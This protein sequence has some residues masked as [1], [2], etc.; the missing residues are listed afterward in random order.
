MQANLVSQ[1]CSGGTEEV[2]KR[3]RDFI[4]KRSGTYDYSTTG[5][6]WT[7]HD[8]YYLSSNENVCAL[9]DWFV[10]KSTGEDGDRDLYYR[11][12]WTSS[13]NLTIEGYLYWN[14]VS[15]VGVSLFSSAENI[16]GILSGTV[17]LWIYGNLNYFLPITKVSGVYYGQY[18]GLLNRV[19][20]NTEVARL[21]SPIVA[22]L[23][24]TLYLDT[25]PTEDWDVGKR[26]YIRDNNH[27]ELIT[28][29]YRDNILK[30]IRTNLTYSY[31]SGAKLCFSLSNYLTGS[32][33]ISNST[34]S[35]R[36]LIGKN[37]TLANGNDRYAFCSSRPT[38]VIN[39]A[40]DPQNSEYAV[41]PVT[42]SS[43][44]GTTLGYCGCYEGVRHIIN[45]NLVN[46][47]VLTDGTDDWRYFSCYGASSS[48]I[49]REV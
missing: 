48:I 24:R 22:G 17:L 7:L 13:A 33:I 45:T 25:L 47:D 38:F 28:I 34:A 26:V 15:H 19:W 36:L 18:T 9:N 35:D 14:N 43:G 29:N 4:C 49:V 2:F 46:E 44:S 27:A 5:I 11:I 40:P 30:E 42:V 10:I 16:M 20:G 8:T 21:L 23:N 6:G 39:T 12:K 1:I 3:L 41:F 31:N 37:G 32:S